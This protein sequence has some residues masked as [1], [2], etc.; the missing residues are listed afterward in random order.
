MGN[1]I[2]STR[3]CF[4]LATMAALVSLVSFGIIRFFDHFSPSQGDQWDWISE[5]GDWVVCFVCVGG[6][7]GGLAWLKQWVNN[8][9][10]NTGASM[11]NL[12]P[13]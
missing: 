12:S 8:P 11:P 10:F 13:R 9:S 4:I 5:M 1:M 2:L 7:M 3:Y 6:S